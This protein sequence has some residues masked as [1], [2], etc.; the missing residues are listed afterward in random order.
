MCFRKVLGKDAGH[1]FI[2]FCAG[3]LNT[4]VADEYVV[5]R[6]NDRRA[7]KSEFPKGSSELRDLFIAM[8]P[9]IPGVRHQLI[10]RYLF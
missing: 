4:T 1:G 10:N 5:V 2:A 8:C 9:G 3:S 7:D 6:I